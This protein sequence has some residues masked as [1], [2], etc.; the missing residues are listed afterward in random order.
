[1]S[2]ILYSLIYMI[3]L[4][5]V[6]AAEFVPCVSDMEV[7]ADL[8]ML[9]IPM[10]LASVFLSVIAN[11][12]NKIRL[13]L[14]AGIAAL[15]LGVILVT[16]R[17]ARAEWLE[18][19]SWIWIS[20]AVTVG[21]ALIAVL[22]LKI[23]AVKYAVGLAL[24]G[25]LISS[26]WTDW[27]DDKIS[28]VSI[29]FLA[30]TILIETVRYRGRGND[31]LKKY[32]VRIVPFLLAGMIGLY[33][34]PHSEKP[35]DWAL[36]RRI[37]DKIS[38]DITIFVQ[39]F[40]KSDSATDLMNSLGFGETGDISGDVADDSKDM[41][42]VTMGSNAPKY[43]Y[44]DGLC[45]EQFDGREWTQDTQSYPNMMDYLETACALS[46]V[47]DNIIHDYRRV[48]EITVTYTGE[49]TRYVF[50]PAK[51]DVS[52]IYV[53]DVQFDRSGNETLFT[54][55]QGYGTSYK[56]KYLLL[57]RN[58]ELMRTLQ[59]LGSSIDEL[60]WR[61]ECLKHDLEDGNYSYQAFLDY[62]Q[63]L[64][65]DLSR[66]N[67]TGWNDLSES[68]QNFVMQTTSGVSDELAKLEAL[69]R[70]FDGFEYTL[71]PGEL[72]ADV[73]SPAEFLD[74]FITESKK[75]Y[76]NSFA[77]AFV[78]LCRAQ[79]IPARYV[80]GYLVPKN[81]EGTSTVKS[82]MAHAYAEAYIKGIGWIV[83]DPTP[84]YY[85]GQA[86]DERGEYELSMSFDYRGGNSYQYGTQEDSPELL[87][88]EPDK[89][90]NWYIIVIPVALCLAV[91][92]AVAFIERALNLRRYAR[93][94]QNERARTICTRIIRML[95]R[96][97][98]VRAE[99]ETVS[100]FSARV[101]L[102]GDLTLNT[103]RSTLEIVLY[104][105][106]SV[107]DEELTHLENEYS[108]I[109]SHLSGRK[110]ITVNYLRFLGLI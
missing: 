39:S 88:E 71:T 16:D 22:M 4:I 85:V 51:A 15:G 42:T 57:N 40:D 101:S 95:K 84:G 29:V 82:S 46:M 17:A 7:S 54:D 70:A 100:E 77:T 31:L 90:T 91:L 61:Q 32:V 64:Y 93:L 92:T 86:W 45:F 28:I 26:Y 106:H 53:K 108:E 24:I 72:P 41:M 74:Y 34:I 35:Y 50:A 66:E 20:L 11:V 59:Y 21:V 68:V 60:N 97:G 25:V 55:R 49:N 89:P 105:S 19:N 56:V 1:M 75:G 6:A 47:N 109:Y 33:Y 103:F 38:D 9:L 96:L 73:D 107:S 14:L 79:G 76:C 18:T 37:I 48:E 83:F 102:E 99:S 65:E 87:Q 44:L 80:H 104:S 2:D 58:G 81:A 36:A 78:L 69:E 110:R 43:L 5:L 23:R 67:G 10:I 98:Y 63:S 52:G 13:I 27:I 94:S 12:A 30:L 8:K 62:R 3:P